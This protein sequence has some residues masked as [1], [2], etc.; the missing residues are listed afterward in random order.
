MPL[1]EQSDL[2][3]KYSWN[4]VLPDNPKITGIPDSVLLNRNEGFEVLAFINRIATANNWN[5]KELGLKTE[6]LIR[7]Q[8]P[9]Y[10]RSHARVLQWLIS[11][12]DK[13]E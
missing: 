10:T 5:E 7:N 6:R 13:Y 2:Q 12:W 1:L 11:N 3:F 9:R 4:T 8:L